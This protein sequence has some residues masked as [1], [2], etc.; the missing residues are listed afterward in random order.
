M[1]AGKSAA[2]RLSPQL[3]ATAIIRRERERL[4]RLPC[5][6]AVPFPANLLFILEAM[7]QTRGVGGKP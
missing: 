7:P 1:E 4:C 3:A 5:G 6:K 2:W